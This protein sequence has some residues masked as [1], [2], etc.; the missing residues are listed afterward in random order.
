MTENLNTHQPETLL[1]ALSK[2]SKNNIFRHRWRKTS[3]PS[4]HRVFE[5]KKT[6]PSSMTENWNIE[7]P[8]T[9]FKALLELSK[10][11][12]FRHRWRKTSKHCKHRVFLAK[13]FFPSS[14]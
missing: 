4:K 6:F 1:G 13:I 2:L 11:N 10:N 14:M 9:Q 12:I 5:R 7:H 3:K 8:T